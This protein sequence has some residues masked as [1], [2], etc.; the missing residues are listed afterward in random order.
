MKN[1]VLFIILTI[2][3]SLLY[4][5]KHNHSDK[6][7]IRY[8]NASPLN[9]IKQQQLRE[10]SLWQSFLSNNP[11]WFVM[12][13]ENNQ[14]PHKAFGEPIQL[15][16][17]SNADVLNFLSTTSFTLPSDL[18]IVSNTKND[19]YINF[20]FNQF[21]NDIEVINSKIYAKLSLDNKLL[22]FGLDIYNDINIDINPLID[23]NTAISAAKG[24]IS[25]PITDVLVQEKLM[26]LPIPNNGKYVYHLVYVVRFKTRIDEGPAH[27]TCYVDA[28]DATLLMRK[29]EVMYEAPPSGTA[30]VSGDIYTEGPFNPAT[31]EKFKYLKAVDQNTLTNYY[32]DNNGEVVLPMNLGS[33][34]RYK[35]EGFYSD[36]Q[37]N[38]NTPDIYANLSPSNTI[39]FDNSNS[40]IQERTAYWAVNEVHDHF[41]NVFPSFTGLDSPME[42]NIDE[43][44]S[45]NAFFAGSSINFYAEG[46]GCQA[47]AKIP[48][49]V[50][51]EYG[52]AINSARYNSGSGMWNGALN[53]GFADVWAFTI[54]SSPFIG[55]GW[56]LVDPSINIRDYQDRKFYPQDLVGE[57]HADGEIIAGCFWDTY[58]NL[59]NINQTLDLFKYTFDSG[60]DGPDGTEGAIFTDILLEVLYAD[61]NDADLTNGT[62]NDIAI[63]SAFA[64]H[65]ITLL[66]NAVISHNPLTIADGNLPITINASVGITY[67]WA[68]G[69]TNCFYRLND[70]N[71]WN[72]I[73]MSGTS[74]FSTTIPAQPNG[75]VIAYYISL[76]DNYGNESG[77]TPMA[78]NL[79][80]IKN[81]NLPYFIM[82]GYDLMEEE[83]FDFSTGFWQTGDVDDNATT[84]LWEIGSP[85]GSYTDNGDPVQTDQQHTNGGSQCLYTGNAPSSSDGIGTNDVDGGHTTVFSPSYDLSSYVKPAFSYWRWFTNN[86]GANPGADWWQVMI[87]D[88]GV[89]WHYVEN[90]K[91]SDNS[92]RKFVFRVS[93]YVGLTSNVQLR[94]IASD[95]LRPGQNL[96]GGSLIEAA[97]DDLMLYEA[98]SGNTSINDALVTKPRLI[99]VTDILG[100]EINIKTVAK[101]TT[102]FYIYDDGSVE[103]R[104]MID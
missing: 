10:G 82:V 102:L 96:D 87:T 68:L 16:G 4:A 30:T 77:I 75:T 97:I 62:P 48:D 40:T 17:S 43:A 49:V 42:T 45:C 1:K 67:P 88:D 9:I 51:H 91:S 65:G 54:T 27:Y 31:N 33:Q 47:T 7:E 44:G 28:K 86:T 26:I 84:G 104:I 92:W 35:L 23:E 61:D 80:P 99:K 100:K 36:V 89:N 12:F 2:S 18:R 83:D 56:D 101:H 98:Q 72:N 11:N 76:S 38:G 14:L 24:Q 46:N 60:V 25:Q 73:P 63:I 39:L 22:A 32:T 95:S 55:Q 37:T 29:N 70:A 20:N 41:K 64:L 57:V 52:H 59:N 103:K 8:F 79:N 15:N 81:A 5:T 90:N 69:S 94:F 58:L 13:D 21:Y 71:S 53:E 3:S 66:S 50:Y 78:A 85:V 19:K 93:D 34:V 74:S 6:N